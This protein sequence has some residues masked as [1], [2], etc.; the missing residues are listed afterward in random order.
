MTASQIA[1]AVRE[2]DDRIRDAILR[3]PFQA[4]PSLGRGSGADVLVKWECDQ[5]TGSFKL[6]GALSFVR[7][8]S[9]AERERG[10]V[11]ASTG[12][13]GL[14]M[15]EAA[16][17]EGL[18]L[19]LFVPLSIAPVKRARLLAAGAEVIIAGATCEQSEIMARAAA[20]SSGRVYA[21][22]YNDLRVVAGQGTLGL[23]IAAAAPEAD[24]VLVPVGG[25]GLAGGIAGFIRSRRGKT[26]VWGVEPA[27]SA[28]MSAS[29][30]AGRLVEVAEKP[31]LADAV[32]G[33][34]EPG[35]VTFDLC[36]DFL[37][38][39]L[40]VPE[41]AIRSAAGRLERCHGRPVEGAGALPLA[42]LSTHGRVFRSRTVV[43][44][45]SGGNAAAGRAGELPKAP[46]SH[47][48]K[49]RMAR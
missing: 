25:G 38:G 26:R 16:R 39:I 20:A 34:I 43:L 10:I 4:V 19:T 2:A 32:A 27:G 48:M 1:A 49:P 29:L 18:K 36:R 45:V 12:N 21:S 30:A 14:A 8:L 28:F 7:A 42:A 17:R 9:P 46:L 24:D 47:K 5:R 41:P 37:A 44:V 15:V 6:R 40:T 23:E 22:P 13:H 33:G 11:A 31:T 3:T 35:A